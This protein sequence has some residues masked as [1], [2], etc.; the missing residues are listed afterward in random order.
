MCS[1]DLI[2][3]AEIVRPRGIHGEVK[4]LLCTDFP[5]RF[6]RLDRVFVRH[7]ERPGI[8][9]LTVQAVRFH[10][11]ALLMS[12]EEI[13]TVEEAQQLRGK[14]ILIPRDEAVPLPEGEY[15]VFDLI[16]LEVVDLEGRRI[17]ILEDI[18]L[19]SAHDVYVVRDQG[20][21]ILVPAVRE[22][23]REI[24]VERGRMTVDP[25]RGLVEM[26]QGIS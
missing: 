22:I 10:G 8:R 9:A 21:E 15:Y 1:E 13:Q 4:A 16:G 14:E 11:D 5:E 6:R 24:D 20:H 3:I 19:L 26:Y 25:P 17:G 23:V 2:V 12:F 18:L 7:K